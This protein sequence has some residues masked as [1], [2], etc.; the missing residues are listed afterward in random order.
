[1]GNPSFADGSPIKNGGFP[2]QKVSLPDG[3]FCGPFFRLGSNEW[4]KFFSGSEDPVPVQV[5]DLPPF[6]NLLDAAWADAQDIGT[7]DWTRRDETKVPAPFRGFISWMLQEVL[8]QRLGS[9]G[10]NPNISNLLIS[11]L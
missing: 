3:I 9:V 1:M 4:V 2:L 6:T 11:R 7:A 10:Y 8:V 5:V